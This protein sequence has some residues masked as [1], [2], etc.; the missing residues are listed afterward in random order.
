MHGLC[1]SEHGSCW[2]CDSPFRMAL[3]WV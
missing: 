3:L 2:G 1:G